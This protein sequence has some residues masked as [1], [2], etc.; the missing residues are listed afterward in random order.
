MP[1]AKLLRELNGGY[2]LRTGHDRHGK[3]VNL[4]FCI[5]PFQSVLRP[6]IEVSV[7]DDVVFFAFQNGGHRKHR[8]RKT[9]ILG[10]HCSRM[11]Q[12]DHCC[13]NLPTRMKKRDGGRFPRS[14]DRKGRQAHCQPYQG[15]SLCHSI[16]RSAASRASISSSKKSMLRSA[17]ERK[18]YF[19]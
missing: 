10:P 14:R 3:Y 13:R 11:E 2:H 7:D 1:P 18:P 15:S 4:S 12:N 8:Q 5:D 17:S 6:R 16:P 9:A 19:R